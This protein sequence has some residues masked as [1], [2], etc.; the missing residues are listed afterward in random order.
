MFRWLV[1]LLAFLSVSCASNVE[2]FSDL[3]DIA[4]TDPGKL[5]TA[6]GAEH[7]VIDY[8]TGK[9]KSKVEWFGCQL[10]ATSKGTV[11]VMNRDQVGFAN[12]NF[13]KGWIAQSFLSEGWNVLAVNRPGYGEST[14]TM[15]LAGPESL[16]AIEAAVADFYKR[17]EGHKI[18]GVWGYSTG[19]IAASFFAKKN[20]EILW[21][22]LGGGIYDA[23]QVVKSSGDQWLKTQ[24]TQLKAKDPNG[25][26]EK[27]SIAWDFEGI[28]KTVLIYHGQNDASVSE[29]QASSFRD[30]LLA[31]EYKVR[32]ILLNGMGHDLP[33]DVHVGVIKKLLSEQAAPGK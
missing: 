12:D 16:S 25:A 23:E 18:S 22:M 7:F 28:P 3:E 14:G 21:L 19:A 10:K 15:D 5:N 27:R 13:C 1:G 4:R 6:A 29:A 9:T 2:R 26:F 11:L 8:G 24:L 33:A 20:P 17:H 32:L 31:Q 30:S